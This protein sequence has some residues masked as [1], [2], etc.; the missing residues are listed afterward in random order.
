MTIDLKDLIAKEGV[1]NLVTPSDEPVL[2][3]IALAMVKS[4]EADEVD[5]PLLFKCA[6]HALHEFRRRSREK[7]AMEL[8]L[9]VRLAVV[10]SE[11]G[12]RFYW[13]VLTADGQTLAASKGETR[14]DRNQAR[15]K[16]RELYMDGIVPVEL[17]PPD[18]DPNA[19][20]EWTE[21]RAGIQPPGLTV[22][23]RE[24]KHLRE[25][26]QWACSTKSESF[27]P[28]PATQPTTSATPDTSSRQN[29]WTATCRYT[30]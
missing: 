19:V 29:S 16:A 27:I 15:R 20:G 21:N 22:R 18:I 13:R 30:I 17:I 23:Q 24:K 14:G 12:T 10:A 2:A 9:P 4:Q 3:Q 7:Q 11:G 26:K 6:I 28:F 5:V 8:D 1:R 25:C